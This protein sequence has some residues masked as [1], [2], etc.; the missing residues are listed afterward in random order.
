M[1]V[2]FTLI[3]RPYKKSQIRKIVNNLNFYAIWLPRITIEVK[4]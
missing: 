3:P 2:I 1:Y 4:R